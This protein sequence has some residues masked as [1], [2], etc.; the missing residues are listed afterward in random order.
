MLSLLW[1]DI[2]ISPF[3]RTR[4]RNPLKYFYCIHSG[5]YHPI[6]QITSYRDFWFVEFTYKERH[7]IEIYDSHSDKICPQSTTS[8][9]MEVDAKDKTGLNKLHT[10]CS[11]LLN[12]ALGN[13]NSYKKLYF[14]HVTEQSNG[15][16]KTNDRYTSRVRET[17][18]GGN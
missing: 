7:Y 13:S 15:T 6:S 14:P 1:Y 17:I 18:S 8:Y 9:R 12:A 10:I 11:L 4:E 3:S 5:P 2:P 16:R